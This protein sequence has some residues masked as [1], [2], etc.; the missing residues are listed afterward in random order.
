M[1]ISCVTT[2]DKQSAS[3]IRNLVHTRCI[4]VHTVEIVVFTPGFLSIGLFCR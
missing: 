4:N 1:A 3:V 2:Y